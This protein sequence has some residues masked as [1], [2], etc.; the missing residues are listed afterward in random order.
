MKK[1]VDY[2][3]IEEQRIT[4]YNIL[5]G[6]ASPSSFGLEAYASQSPLLECQQEEGLLDPKAEPETPEAPILDESHVT[7][8][9]I[10]LFDNGETARQRYK[11]KIR[12]N[13]RDGSNAE[14]VA[15]LTKDRRT[16]TRYIPEPGR[17]DVIKYADQF[18][19]EVKRDHNVRTWLGKPHANLGRSSKK[20]RNQIEPESFVAVYYDQIEHGWSG[21]IKIYNF[22]ILFDLYDDMTLK[23]KLSGVKGQTL[24][25]NSK[26]QLP[27]PKTWAQRTGR[28]K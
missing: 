23:Q 16:F 12:I 5:E 19:K 26:Y 22:V 13:L 2:Y 18:A 1:G 14:F 25:I 3:N 10:Q 4:K 9:L 6:L 7:R 15:P 28:S 20:T 24:W 27:R 17:N 11:L 21:V 8:C